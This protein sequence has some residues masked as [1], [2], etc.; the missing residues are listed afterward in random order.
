[1]NNKVTVIVQETD[2]FK[3]YQTADF[4][5][6]QEGD[7]LA[8][9]M[10]ELMNLRSQIYSKEFRNMIQRITG[11][12]EL[13]DRTDLSMN[14]YASS[15]HLLCHDDV[16]GTR[17]VSFIIY[18]T[19][20]DEPWTA[21]DGG[22][23]ELY[24]LDE[25][26][27]V[28]VTHGAPQGVPSPIPT[29]SLLPIFNSMALFTVQ[30][31]RSYHAVQ[32]VFTDE[33][34]RLSISGWFHAATPPVGSDMASLCQIMNKE[35]PRPFENIPVD[36]FPPPPFSSSDN[37]DCLELLPEDKTLLK[38][39]L[40]P[41]YLQRKSIKQIHES[42]LSDSSIQLHGFLREDIVQSLLTELIATDEKDQ[43]GQ[44]RVP[45]SYSVGEGEG[46]AVNGPPHK[47]RYLKYTPPPTTAPATT[48]SSSA[49]RVPAGQTL[50]L[51]ATSLMKSPAFLRYLHILTSLKVRSNRLEVR[52]FRAGLDYTVAHHGTLVEEPLLDAT[53]CFVKAEG[54]EEGEAWESG[55]TG[56]FECYI[57]ADE[58]ADAA[59]SA[60]VYR[61]AN[62]DDDSQLMSIQ[63]GNNVL[64]I[65]MRDPGVMR[66]IKYVSSR[67]PSSRWDVS[68]E[69][70]LEVDSDDED[71]EDE[72]DEGSGEG[73]GSTGG[74]DEN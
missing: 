43:L 58:D 35:T 4:G 41:I 16:I 28:T 62:D 47:Q 10:P 51:I 48:S 73:E 6:L 46:W 30:P 15:C 59:A 60:E 34:P 42:F 50:H 22:A 33:K 68:A 7:E 53:L 20:P 40:N 57:E 74:G 8:E 14:A 2:L 66:F 23:L 72:N 21:E 32:E 65:V 45:S 24:P 11:C 17:C 25:T 39:F 9:K 31:G 64:N 63:A 19:D 3:V 18:L 70:E 5:N 26:E 55:D 67:A 13:T 27:G 71:S 56:G 37:E 38:K 61:S 69:Y 52:R 1:M 54:E 12:T 44:K 49:A 36:T 29:T